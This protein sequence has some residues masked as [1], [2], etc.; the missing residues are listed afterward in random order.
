MRKKLLQNRSK[1]N[2]EIIDNNGMIV[3]KPFTN[4][5]SEDKKQRDFPIKEES[6]LDILFNELRHYLNHALVLY[7]E[8]YQDINA[9]QISMAQI[10]GSVLGTTSTSL[11]F[12]GYIFDPD[13]MTESQQLDFLKKHDLTYREALKHSSK[14]IM[15]QVKAFIIK[16]KI[17]TIISWGHCL[18]YKVLENE[19]YQDIIPS[20]MKTFDLEEI[21][22]E[23][24][25]NSNNLSL[26]L[27]KFCSVLNFKNHG[28]WHNSMDDVKMIKKICDLYL[29]TLVVAPRSENNFSTLGSDNDS[30]TLVA[31][32]ED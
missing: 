28:K 20:K 6:N 24:N 2:F 18:D 11:T 3:D 12:N 17:N 5:I 8:F 27:G 4:A 14:L 10:S 9:K 26:N 21:L 29:S 13:H 23:A 15:N 7:L 22:A 1:N 16:N 19:G 30:L 25:G 32:A 31:P